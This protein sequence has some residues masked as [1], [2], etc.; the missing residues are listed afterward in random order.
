MC[1]RRREWVG[2]HF[3]TPADSWRSDRHGLTH[4]CGKQYHYRSDICLTGLKVRPREALASLRDTTGCS[5][6]QRFHRIPLFLFDSDFHTWGCKMFFTGCH[7]RFSVIFVTL[8]F[9]NS[10][11]FYNPFHVKCRYKLCGQRPMCL[12]L[13]RRGRQLFLSYLG[14]T[15][16]TDAPAVLLLWTRIFDF[17]KS[18]NGDLLNWWCSRHT[19][20]SLNMCCRLGRDHDSHTLKLGK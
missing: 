1:V 19:C 6:Q 3:S 15:F 9:L 4:N 17:D 10:Y 8:I 11:R 12:E 13:T 5:K 18:E 20:S 16:L 2:A 7:C 14:A